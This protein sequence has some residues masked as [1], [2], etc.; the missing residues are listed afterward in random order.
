MSSEDIQISK[1]ADLDKLRSAPELNKKQSKVLLIELIPIL[2]KSDWVTIGIMAPSLKKGIEAI[3]NIEKKLEYN[4]MK[5]ITLPIS[6][7]PIFLKAN[8]KT[9]EIHARIEYG[10]G[11][12][13]L[14]SCQNDD[15]SLISKTIGPLPLDFFD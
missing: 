13:I 12:G 3:R 10:L 8:Q 2:N 11:E 5:C 4:E 6:E 7:G 14:I 1:L 15:N 9:G